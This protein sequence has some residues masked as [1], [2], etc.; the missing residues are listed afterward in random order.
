MDYRVEPLPTRYLQPPRPGK[1]FGGSKLC[2]KLMRLPNGVFFT[3]SDQFADVHTGDESLRVDGYL[4]PEMARGRQESKREVAFGQLV[5]RSKSQGE[6]TEMVAIKP[7]PSRAVAHEFHASE[8]VAHALQD[9]HGRRTTF[10]TLGFFRDEASATVNLV[11]RYEHGVKSTDGL[12]WN[13]TTMPSTDQVIDVLRRAAISLGD[14]HG[15]A[16]VAHGDSQPKNIAADTRGVRI[17]DLEDAKDFRNSRGEIDTLR[18]RGLMSEDLSLFL[19]RLGGDYAYLVDK[20][21][22]GIYTGRVALGG[23]IPEFAQL[24]RKQVQEIAD[25]PQEPIPYL[26]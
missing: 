24:Q 23:V 8:R 19:R 16:A 2:N 26:T 13:R 6:Y 10:T 15:K 22:T 7:M 14:L 21:F 12:M 20:H 5:L 9:V 4:I 25:Q 18:A 11:T 17:I 3:V 1:D